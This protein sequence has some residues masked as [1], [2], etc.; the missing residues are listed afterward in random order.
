M[1]LE[2]VTLISIFTLAFGTISGRIE[3][4]M[5]TP[6]M[7]FVGFGLLMS[8]FV[9]RIL[10]LS[11]DSDWINIIATTTLVFVLFTDASRI[12][13]K[14]LRHQYH[15]PLRL[16]GI[17]LPLTIGLGCVLAM[18]IFPDLNLWEAAALSTILAP[19]DAALGQAVVSSP[20][21]P[22][23]IRQALN[24][25]SGLN[26]GICLPILLTFLS[27]AESFGDGKTLGDWGI[28][29]LGQLILGPV[30]GILIG[31]LGGQIV[32]LTARTSWMNEN[33]Q[34]LSL[35]SIAALA[36]C[37]AEPIG[38]NGFIAAFCAGLTLGNTAR[39]LCP[40]LYEYGETEGQ[41][42]I[43]LTF[44]IFGGLMVIPALEQVDSSVLLY[45]MLS[46]TA[47]RIIGV[48]ISMSGLGL[49]WDTQAFLGWFGPRGVASI[50]YLL[51]VLDHK[52]LQGGSKIFIIVVTTVFFSVLA[53]GLTAFSGAN[54]YADR[55][56]KQQSLL[57][58]EQLPVEAMPVRLPYKS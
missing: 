55:V 31:Y 7:V 25:E 19:T 4:S 29:A 50:L 54:W 13:L 34:R 14:L 46:L 24:V 30:A 5:I 2:T 16:L 40:R 53:H 6:P 44:V 49:R 37:F 10:N 52:M 56:K 28:F 12:D 48:V 57:Q 43:L 20:N 15:L 17:G 18:V 27:L 23:R 1:I 26:D 45:A 11:I 39:D 47:A 36:Y 32:T 38:G 33:Y 35:L 22:I 51:L 3:K 58:A 42:F 41:F 9:A 8:P 21:V